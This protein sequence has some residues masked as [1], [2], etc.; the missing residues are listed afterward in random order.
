MFSVSLNES[1]ILDA[2]CCSCVSVCF[3]PPDDGFV[4]L[5]VSDEYLG[6]GI[7]GRQT[8]HPH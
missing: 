5:L 3:C 2:H 1:E 7:W 8:G 6:G 4:L